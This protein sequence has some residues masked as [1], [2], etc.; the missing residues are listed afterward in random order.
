MPKII[1]NLEEKLLQQTQ[2]Q[3]RQ[4][5]YSAVTIRSVAKACGVGVGTV[6]NYFPSKDALV[7]GYLLR[8]WQT[9]LDRITRCSES[10]ETLEPVARSIY[11]ELTEYAQR[12]R[13]VFQDTAAAG[14]FAGSF[15]RYHSLLRSQISQPVRR[16]APSDFAASFIAEAMLTWTMAGVSFDTLYGVIEPLLDHKK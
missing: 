8:D 12:H 7:A 14:A 2:C 11:R 10:A 6:Y 1:E 13:A 16:F 4:G 15:S 5:G 3:L 9:C